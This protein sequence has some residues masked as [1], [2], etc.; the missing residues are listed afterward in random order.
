MEAEPR[1]LRRRQRRHVRVEHGG[2]AS[3]ARWA[4]A[5]WRRGRTR[6]PTA[7]ER[8]GERRAHDA[9]NAK[10]AAADDGSGSGCRGGR[11]RRRARRIPWRRPRRRRAALGVRVVGG[12]QPLQPDD[13]AAVAEAQREQQRPRHPNAPPRRRSAVVVR[14]PDADGAG[15]GRARRDGGEREADGGEARRSGERGSTARSLPAVRELLLPAVLERPADG[16]AVRGAEAAA[17]DGAR[18]TR[19]RRPAEERAARCGGRR[20]R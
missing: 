20:R 17:T 18:L 12:E 13:G 14:G 16:D 5:R 9:A 7:G 4:A 6:A 10:A 11:R 3:S 2:A 15:S 8:V 1:V 19:Q